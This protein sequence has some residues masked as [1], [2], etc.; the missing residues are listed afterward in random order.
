MDLHIPGFDGPFAQMTEISIR[1]ACPG[2]LAALVAVQLE[3]WRRTYRDELPEDYRNGA[4]EDDLKALW[5]AARLDRDLVLVAEIGGKIVGLSGVILEAGRSAYLD[6]LHVAKS[7]EGQGVGRALLAGTAKAV[8]AHERTR[9]HL[10]VVT[11]NARALGFYETMG[12]T[13]KAAIQD[14]MF[15]HAVWAYPIQWDGQALL[16]LSD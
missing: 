2:D 1:K 8:L 13:R 12:G 7:A 3:S 10:T 9:L 11:G 16:R 15:G 4:M 14:A 5:S 6:N